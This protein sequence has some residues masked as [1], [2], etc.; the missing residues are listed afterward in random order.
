MVN[1]INDLLILQENIQNMGSHLRC[2]EIP[3]YLMALI[4][5]PLASLAGKYGTE[6]GRLWH[7]HETRL[8]IT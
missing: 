8:I 6:G 1:Y 4:C 7:K 3:T 2:A 5:G